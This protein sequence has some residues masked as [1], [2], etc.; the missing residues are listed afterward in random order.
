MSSLK[1]N[2]AAN[3]LEICRRSRVGYLHIDRL[4]TLQSGFTL[5][6]ADDLASSNIAGS[7]IALITNRRRRITNF[8]GS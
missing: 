3:H 6:V 1:P 8:L 2:R 7:F 4:A 5:A